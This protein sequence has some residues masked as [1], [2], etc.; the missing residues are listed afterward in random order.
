MRRY[1]WDW[2]VRLCHLAFIG[3]CV[4]AYVTYQMSKMD[5]H[6]WSGYVVLGA[7]AVRLVWG[8]IG[9]PNARFADFVKGP[10]A[11]WAYVSRWKNQP[12][13]TGH[14]PL[15]GYAVLALLAALA[16]QTVTGLFSDDEVATA[17]PLRGWVSDEMAHTLTHIHRLSFNALLAL[18][19][20]HLTAIAAYAVIKRV[21]LVGPMIT[22]WTKARD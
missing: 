2:V 6:A 22:G 21:N 10:G 3:G 19:A 18:V 16:V 9:S 7:L 15:G 12:A 11:V 14:N 4:S 5:W 8:L 20:L 1:V 17:G 13:P